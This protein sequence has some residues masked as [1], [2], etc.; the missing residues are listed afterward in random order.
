MRFRRQCELEVGI[1]Q[2]D[3][4]TVRRA[5]SNLCTALEVPASSMALSQTSGNGRPAVG[6]LVQSS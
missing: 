6:D 5:V 4:E 2:A 1:C 3:S